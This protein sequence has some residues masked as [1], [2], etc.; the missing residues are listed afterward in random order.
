MHTGTGMRVAPD[1][2]IDDGL[3]D[4][5][6]VRDVPRLRR[7]ALLRRALRGEWAPPPH[8]EYRQVRSLALVPR[9]DERLNVDGEATGSTP[10]TVEVL[11]GAVTLVA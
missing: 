1:A 2:R 5:V 3:L 9:R 11:P 6:L 7:P 10:V 8:V 4:L